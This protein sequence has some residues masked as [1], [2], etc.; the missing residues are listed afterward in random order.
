MEYFVVAF[1]AFRLLQ[2]HVPGT[3]VSAL[4]FQAVSNGD[5]GLVEFKKPDRLSAVSM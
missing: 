5:G 2:A 4:V 1:P 3:V